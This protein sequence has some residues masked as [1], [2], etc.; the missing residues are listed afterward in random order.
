MLFKIVQ[1][2]KSGATAAATQPPVVGASTYREIWTLDE[3][4]VTEE[5]L[6]P[7]IQLDVSCVHKH[8]AS[9]A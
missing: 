1:L 9:M 7:V 5:V 3:M 4:Q 2:E 8:S 6:Q